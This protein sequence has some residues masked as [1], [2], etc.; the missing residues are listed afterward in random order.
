MKRKKDGRWVRAICIDGKRKYFYSTADTEAKAERD[1]RKQLLEYQ[2]EGEKGKLFRIVANDW[3]RSV[4][5][6]LTFGTVK[7]YKAAVEDLIAEFGDIPI[8]SITPPSVMQYFTKIA[9]QGY[10]AKS[11]MRRRSVLNMI[12]KYA[13]GTGVADSNFILDIPSPKKL[14]KEERRALTK[15]E[16]SKIVANRKNGYWGALAYFILATGARPGEAFAL[17]FRDVDIERQTVYICKIVEHQGNQGIIQN[18]TKTYSGERTLPLTSDVVDIIKQMRGKKDDLL[19]PD[20][21]NGGIITKNHYYRGWKEFRKSLDL[22]DDLSLYNL[23]HTYATM[24]YDNEIDVKSAQY[25]MGHKD[26]TTTLKIYTHLTEQK[27]KKM[28][29]DLRDKIAAF[30]VDS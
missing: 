27:K 23:R 11:V 16:Q 26:A 6:G 12:F 21:Q 15:D 30:L 22:A 19:F 2:Q 18:R 14:P 13:I 10:S 20:Q 24:L 9:M 5:D 4:Y 3:E 7:V 28:N 29:L 17:T 1:I 25:L 8:K